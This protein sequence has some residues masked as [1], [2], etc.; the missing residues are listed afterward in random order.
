MRTSYIRFCILGIIALVLTACMSKPPD[1]FLLS[2]FAGYRSDITNVQIV[3]KLRCDRISTPAKILGVEDAWLVTF[4]YESEIIPDDD[5]WLIV[6]Y[7]NV[8]G[9]WLNGWVNF[10]F[11]I[12]ACP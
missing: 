3:R 12:D 11:Q 8:D 7:V 6:L 2:D 4:D 5:S 1:D 10:E 9:N